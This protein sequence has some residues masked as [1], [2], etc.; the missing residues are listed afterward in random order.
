MKLGRKHLLV[1]GIVLLVAFHM[2]LVFSPIIPVE[3]PYIDVVVVSDIQSYR[4]RTGGVWFYDVDEE[5][6]FELQRVLEGDAKLVDIDKDGVFDFIQSSQPIP[7]NYTFLHTRTVYKSM[8]EL[9]LG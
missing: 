8:V 9:L 5:G 6:I 1:G 4:L 3:E 2:V 7:E